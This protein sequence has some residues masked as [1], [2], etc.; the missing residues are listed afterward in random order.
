M[1]RKYSDIFPPSGE[2]GPVLAE[3]RILTGW[4]TLGSKYSATFFFWEIFAIVRKYF[5][6]Y[7]SSQGDEPSAGRRGREAWL[8]WKW[9]GSQSIIGP[10][11]VFDRLYFVLS[12]TRSEDNSIGDGTYMTSQQCWLEHAIFRKFWFDQ[13]LTDLTFQDFLR[14]YHLVVTRA[15]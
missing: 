10:W 7:I 1:L 9:G 4:V 3:Q 13:F 14:H 11:W 5:V 15:T 2:T 6:T 8:L 12:R